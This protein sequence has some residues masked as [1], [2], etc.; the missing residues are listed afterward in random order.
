MATMM[1]AFSDR[2]FLDDQ[3]QP[4]VSGRVT[5]YVHDS[6]V[7]ADIYTME[8]MDYVHADNPQRL[9]EAG[10]LPASIFTELGVYDVKV[11]KYN[12][13]GSF[14]DFDHFEIGIDAK[15]DQIGRDS[16]KDIDEL[17][18]L[19]PSVSSQIVTVESYPVRSYIWDPEAIDTADGGVV[20]DS[21][22]ADHGKW[23]LLWD[24]P[25]LPSSVYGVKEGDCTNINA[26]FNYA[27]VIG[28]MNIHTPPAIRLEGGMY[29]LSGYYVCP[30]HLALEPGV[31]FTG[32]IALYDELELFG[33]AEPGH[34]Y[35]DFGFL[36][37]G[38]TAH[39]SWFRDLNDFWHCGADILVVDE[40]NYFDYGKDKLSTSVNLSDKTVIGTGTKVSSYTNSAYFQLA[41]DSTVP[42]NFFN[43]SKDYVRIAGAG[44]GD[45]VFTKSGTWDPGPINQGHHVQWDN[46][47]TPDLDLFSNAN[48]WVA[49]MLERRNRLNN[50]LWNDYTLDCQGRT[51]DSIYLGDAS[52]N[53]IKNANFTGTITCAGYGISLINV[54]GAM[55]VNFQ[56]AGNGIVSLNK[57]RVSINRYH[58]GIT[59]LQAIDSDISIVGAEGIDPCDTSIV[60]RGGSF[61]GLVKMSTDNCNAYKLNQQVIFQDCYIADGFS[62]RLNYLQMSG[63]RASGKI[64]LYPAAQGDKFYYN[65]LMEDNKFI[66]NFRLWITYYWDADHP[67]YECRG[68]AVKFNMMKIVN[69]RFDTLDAHAIKMTQWHVGYMEPFIYATSAD[70][71]MGTWEYT[72]NS[73]NCP[74]MAPPRIY[75]YN[76]WTHHYEQPLGPH[77][78]Y[79]SNDVYYLFM[80]WDYEPGGSSSNNSPNSMLDPANPANRVT[81][82]IQ[83]ENTDGDWAACDVWYANGIGT[84]EQ[85]ADEDYNNRFLVYVWLSKP[86]WS[87]DT[88]NYNHNG[89][90]TFVRSGA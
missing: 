21:D 81:A 23:L 58:H 15:L 61:S 4:I 55:S 84:P 68:T 45:D 43:P 88:A 77:H 18:D 85:L 29:D 8:G 75:N 76:N 20:V 11:E 83:E 47:I 51:V 30:K 89:Y 50:V 72:G 1:Q 40:T 44:F 90:T 33:S 57:C 35:G 48:R 78:Y 31:K 59:S 36:H 80:P 49:V 14:E 64:D 63:C 53:V 19:D 39:S 69:N 5:F 28:S 16:V 27:A 82:L 65:L 60:V 66:G 73:G 71:N 7:L 56:H 67:H 2:T 25:Y 22:V 87:T 54:V 9:D 79:R 13:D 74:G 12:G 10:R 62:W 70:Q 86:A 24:C 37:S 3:A 52:F 6:N 42:N 32:T 46:G 41:L 38:L 26:L 17:M 34:A